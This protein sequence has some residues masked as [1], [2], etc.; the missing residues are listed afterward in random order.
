MKLHFCA[1][2]GRRLTPKQ[3]R[4]CGS[5]CRQ[6]DERNSIRKEFIKAYGGKCQ[7]PGGC[8][9][10]VPEFLCLDHL[11]PKGTGD[12]HRKKTKTRG[13]RMYRLLRDLNW[14]KKDFRLL[15]QNCNSA[16]AYF[17]SCPHERQEV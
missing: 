17:G 12:R 14:P 13:W 16:K 15:C 10:S 6:A 1:E 8:N 7:C 11:G 9:V 4:F 3:E 2:C 5:T